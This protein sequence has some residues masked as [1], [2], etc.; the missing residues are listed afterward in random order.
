MRN[1]RQFFS[2]LVTILLMAAIPFY[3]GCG[4]RESDYNNSGA[5]RKIP[6]L[7]GSVDYP[8]GFAFVEV[9]DPLSGENPPYPEPTM[10]V[11]EVGVT[12]E[13]GCFST[14]LTR[15]TEADGIGGRHEYSR[16]DPFNADASMILLV[17]DDGDYAVYRT[18][19]YPYNDA[20]NLVAVTSGIAEPRWD[21]D[22]PESLWG[23]NGFEIVRDNVVSGERVVVKNFSADPAI[24]PI[25]AS[26]PDIYGVTM[27]YEGEASQD[28]RYWAF[29]LRGEEDDYRPRYIL[30]WDRVEDEVLGLYEVQPGESDIDWVGMSPLGTCVLIGGMEYSEGNLVGLTIADRRLR[31]FHRID[32]TTSHADVGLDA[33]GNEVVVMQN[34]RTDYIDMLPLSPNTKPILEAGGDYEGTGR[35]PILRLFYDGGSP[36]D[37]SSGLHVSCNAEGYCL[38][39]THIEPGAPERNW[40]DRCN[41]LVRLDPREPRVFYL[42]KT[43]NTT[44]EYWEETHGA[45]SND[46]SRIV[47]ACNW[48]RDAGSQEVFLL[49]LDMPRDWRE[50]TGVSGDQ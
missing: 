24:A 40:L 5:E 35:I 32:Y 44:A 10:P 2:P 12:F 29:I 45:I 42:S 19:S 20:G 13:D 46:G 43:Y 21:R 23:L 50:L 31:E 26:E 16:V 4:V 6:G 14:L 47:W 37:F 27:N 34:N 15:V 17:R 22:D 36:H 9:P 1:K 38:V 49:R 48:N 33:D 39:S 11:P 3:N 8:P 7:R 18:G 30:C 41:V 28:L 25:L